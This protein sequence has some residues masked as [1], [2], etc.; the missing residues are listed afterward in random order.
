MALLGVNVDH[1]ATVRNARGGHWPCPV[2]GA[3][4]A[5]KFGADGI[6]AHLRE[7]RR[8]ITDNDMMQLRA[9]IKTRL[10]MEMALTDEMVN[11]AV[12]IKPEQVTLVPERREELTTEG[13]LDVLTLSRQPEFRKRLAVLQNAHIAISLFIDPDSSQVKASHDVGAGFVEFHTGRY[14]EKFAQ[15]GLMHEATQAEL[16]ALHQAAA[17]AVSQ[18]LVVNAGHGLTFENVP[19]ILSMAGLHELNIGHFLIAQSIF[20]GLGPVVRQMKDI[21]CAPVSHVA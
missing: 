11:L 7:D 5:E 4:L 15:Y 8:H 16:S 18:G 21:L 14:S 9:N 12:K 20:E 3:L 13:G 6:T 1:I 17:L 10:N 19:P 2:E